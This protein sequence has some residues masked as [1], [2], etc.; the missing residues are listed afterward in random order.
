M[1]LMMMMMVTVMKKITKDY[2]SYSAAGLHGR[3]DH[4]GH[5][6]RDVSDQHGGGHDAG[7][8]QEQVPQVGPFSVQELLTF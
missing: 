5:Q 6:Y 1:M 3:P 2:S 8:R 4:H 7:W